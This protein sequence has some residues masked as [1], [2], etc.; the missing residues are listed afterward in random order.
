[1]LMVCHHLN[2]ADPRGPGLRGVAHPR[3]DHR[4][5]GR[6][7]RSRRHQH[8]VVRLA[9]DGAHRRGDHPHLA[10]RRQ[11]EAPAGRAARRRPARQRARQA[12][13]GQVHDQPRHRPRHRRT[14]S[15]SIEVGKL[16]DLVVWKPAFFG[17]KPELVLKGGLIASAAMGDPNASIPTPQPVRYRPMFAAYGGA[18]RSTSVTFVSQAALEDGVRRAAR[19]CGKV[20]AAG[21]RLPRRSA[22]RA[23]IHN[24]YCRASRSTPRPTRC[25]PTAS[26]SPASRRACCRWPS[27]T[28]CS[29]RGHCV[30]RL[31]RGLASRAAVGRRPAPSVCGKARDTLRLTWEERRWTRRAA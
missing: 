23:M 8:D 31:T 15:G 16:A 14:R 22:R 7:A 17:V 11:D 29:E 25:A 5:R 27:A 3:R 24:A 13:R 18:V 1:M 10:D 28:S 12:L 30:R 2:A 6:A 21:A 20:V 19:A 9:G 26:C 4:R